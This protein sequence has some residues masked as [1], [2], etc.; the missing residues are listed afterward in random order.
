M[1]KLNARR[2]AVAAAALSLMVVPGIGV[3]SDEAVPFGGPL[4]PDKPLAQAYNDSARVL[5]RVDKNPIINWT[6]RIWCET[7]YR[8]LREAGTGQPVDKIVDS[9]VDIISPKGFL[10]LDAAK[11]MPAGGVQFM[12]NAWYFGTDLTGLVIV[13]TDDG[14]IMFD[15]LSSPQDMQTQALDQMEAAGLDP[16]DIK[17]IVMGHQHFDHIGGANLIRSKFAPNAKFVMGGPDAR[18]VAQMREDVLAGK[19]LRFAPPVAASTPAEMEARKQGWLLGI[20]D[21]IDIAVNELP[22][23]TTGIQTIEVGPSTEFV[24]MLTPGHTVGQLSAIVPVKHKGKIHNLLVWSGND[25]IEQADQYAISS[26]FIRGVALRMKA[27]AFINTHAYQGAIFHHL[28]ALKANPGAPNPMLMG[29]DGVQRMVGVFADCQR[30]GAK[31]L[32]DG[33]WKAM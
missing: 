19:P 15:A 30:A 24:A 1:M 26:D 22:G 8:T 28:R 14:L 29:V 32:A 11:P 16:A 6:Y 5:A 21:R 2:S 13:R 27:D 4:E 18:S 17:F 12:D 25:R 33:T 7:G 31:R 3:A 10:Y 23:L 20:P 9:D